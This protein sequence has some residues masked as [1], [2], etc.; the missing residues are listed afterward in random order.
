MRLPKVVDRSK[1]VAILT[2]SNYQVA[3]RV[4]LMK[5]LILATRVIMDTGS[6]VSL[7]REDLLPRDV[8]VKAADKSSASMFD[9]NGGL[10]PIKGTIALH[11]RIGSYT[12]EITVGVV[13][14]MSGPMTLGTDY[15]DLHVPAICGP[16]NYI[17][18]HDG[19]RVPILRR[20]RTIAATTQKAD[21]YCACPSSASASVR[22][23]Q[24][25]V[26]QPRSRGYVQVH[27]A[28]QGNVMV[29]PLHRV[30]G[31]HQIH[32]PSGTMTCTAGQTWWLEI[33]HTGKTTK[34]FLTG[35]NLGLVDRY[36]GNVTAVTTE[37]WQA[38]GPNST[39]TQ[40]H[41]ESDNRPHIYTANVPERFKARL[42]ELIEKHHKLWDG[43]LSLIKATEHRIKLE[44]GAKPV[45]SNHYRIGPRSRQEIRKQ[46]D[47][48]T[49]LDVIEPSSSEWARPIVLVPKPDCSSRFCIDYR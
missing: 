13:P 40:V 1:V 15:T 35:M 48:M 21:M 27:T 34:R 6:G 41:E 12:T 45:R 16:D 47:K 9:I 4:W 36:K 17:R 32:V 5:G 44:P 33:I 37:Q 24:K 7:I 30:F 2:G 11:V 26:I 49:Q 43:S 14:G 23:A 25:K 20:G 18:M 22:L 28:F 19:K 39:P 42:D 3:A 10:L 8:T 38:L 46:V 29:S 31:K